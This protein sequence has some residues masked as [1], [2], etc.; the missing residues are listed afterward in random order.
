[1]ALRFN[2]TLSHY[3]Q[4]TQ[5]LVTVM[6]VSLGCWYLPTTHG[7]LQQGLIQITNKVST[8]AYWWLATSATGAAQARSEQGGGGVNATSAGL[9]TLGQWNHLLAVFT[10][11]TS[12][13][14][15]L[16]GVGPVNNATSEATTGL[17]DTLIGAFFNASGVGAGFANGVIA[18][19]IIWNTA[20]SATDALYLSQIGNDP[21]F[22]APGHI[23]SFPRLSD[24]LFLG[25]YPDDYGGSWAIVGN[26]P[27]VLDDDPF[28][29][30]AGSLRERA[31]YELW[32]NPPDVVWDDTFLDNAIGQGVWVTPT[33]PASAQT[34][35]P[36]GIASG[37][38]AGNPQLN[39]TIFPTGIASGAAL[40]LPQLNFTIHPSGIASGAALGNPQLNLTIHPSGIASGAAL[41]N[42]QLNLIIYPS[43]IVPS[44]AF[45]LAQ[46]N[47]IVHLSGI[48]PGDAFGLAVISIAGAPQTITAF[49]IASLQALG[50][51]ALLTGPK[52]VVAASCSYTDVSVAVALCSAGDTVVIP[53][54]NCV[55]SN[56]LVV[57]SPITIQGTGTNL[58]RAPG[59]IMPFF[60]G[61]G[62]NVPAFTVTGIRFSLEQVAPRDHI[63]RIHAGK[64][65]G[66]PYVGDVPNVWPGP[67]YAIVLPDLAHTWPN[68]GPTQWIDVNQPEND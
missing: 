21:R 33:V 14:I 51:P 25:R 11:A 55:W 7:P 37:A 44:D 53:A 49:G 2:S 50:L 67:L 16:N 42:P 48:A 46:L 47:Q 31:S 68:D 60:C 24:A 27:P 8:A 66:G 54:G 56:T 45:G 36:T 19:P 41:G 62:W 23:I 61:T 30:G 35:S 64:H 1:V 12:R 39:F 63:G 29:L 28:P 57:G 9:V 26:T 40:G 10:S 59:F 58:A 38:A 3:L 52:T 6:P 34:I 4:R 15:Y 18:Y 43:G 32:R 5:P 65:L 13:D 17:T 22:T 20:L